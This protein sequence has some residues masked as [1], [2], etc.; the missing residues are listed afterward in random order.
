VPWSSPAGKDFI[1]EFVNQINPSTVVDIGPGAGAYSKLL[2]KSDQYW[3]CVEIWA[4]YVERY[5]L[6]EL[7]NKVIIADV[8]HWEATYSDVC[9]CGDVIEHLSFLD[10]KKA[11]RKLRRASEYVVISIPL[12]F[13]PQ[14]E[15]EGNPYERHI[16]P[17][18]S[19]DKVLNLGGQPFM[20]KSFMDAGGTKIGVF[21]YDKE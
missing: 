10:A 14:G 13:Y 5:K 12:S 1:V 2:R 19:Y 6:H 16:D 18:W 11:L 20:F 9:I 4:P 7:Y 17:D 21:V 8:L 15:A 3:T